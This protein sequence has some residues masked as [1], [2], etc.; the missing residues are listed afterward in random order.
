M[1]A[2]HLTSSIHCKTEQRGTHWL[3]AAAVLGEFWAENIVNSAKIAQSAVW[4]P[5][6]M[7]NVRRVVVLRTAWTMAANH[8]D[9]LVR[10]EGTS[11]QQSLGQP[12]IG[13]FPTCQSR[14]APIG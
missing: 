7:G 5:V 2:A 11:L 9:Q 8:R 4:L 12:L 14:T 1:S 3:M 6:Q 10:Q 13:D